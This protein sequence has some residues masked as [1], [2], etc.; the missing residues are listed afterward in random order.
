MNP[1]LLLQA[2]P[3]HRMGQQ[4]SGEPGEGPPM[5]HPHMPTHGVIAEGE[6]V[7]VEVKDGQDMVTMGTRLAELQSKC[8][9]Q[10]QVKTL[11]PHVLTFVFDYSS[12]ILQ[13]CRQ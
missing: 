13:C 12:G 11:V 8:E 1:E 7:E 2:A 3:W 6:L 5:H 9:Q 10:H 4:M